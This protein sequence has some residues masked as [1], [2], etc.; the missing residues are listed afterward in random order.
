MVQQLDE[1]EEGL[2]RELKKVTEEES[3]AKAQGHGGLWQMSS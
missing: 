2:E 3:D 1:L